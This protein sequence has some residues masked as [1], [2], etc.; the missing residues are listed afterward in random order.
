MNNITLLFLIVVAVV[1]A[2]QL[3][4][5]SR[6]RRSVEK[7]RTSVP[8]AF[9]TQISL[10]AHQKA[11]DYTVTKISVGNYGLLYGVVFLL[12]WTIGGGLELVDNSVSGFGLSTLWHGVI[13]MFVFMI[14][15]TIIDMPFSLYNTFV[16]EEKF[17]FNRMT[18]KTM[19]GD[20]VKSFLLMIIIG[21]PLLAVILWLM[22]ESGPNWWIYVWAVWMGFSLL[23]L[24]AYPA[25]IA[26]IFNKF[27]P[28]D[29]TQLVERIESLLTRCGFKSHGVFVMD[30]S[31][32]SAHGNAY[33]SGFGSNKRI[34]FFDTLLE[35]LDH[36][37]IEAVLAHELG[38]FRLKHV[39]KRIV[40]SAVITL[41]A[42][43]ILGLLAQ[44][45]WFFN[46]LGV[47]TP[48]SHMALLLFMMV[49]PLLTFFIQPILA[50]GSRK[51]EFEAD[52]FA[53]ENV[54]SKYLITALVKMYEEN[55]STL[56]PDEVYSAFHDSHPPAP[57]RIKHLEQL[58]SS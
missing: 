51:H 27:Q 58:A 10:E 31:K 26:P 46:S 47:S 8:E 44:E 14:A 43:A 48:S 45:Q 33:F 7:H 29:N 42:L 21:V 23:M 9:K 18:V 12:L 39:P 17:G 55:A 38:H 25:V 1:T 56:T 54:N 28:L 16:V 32:R 41:I 37:E 22:N 4:L 35:G 11:A 53:A 2:T 3:Y 6:Q 15:S 52:A 57:I 19:L 20:L 40:L 50:M 49:F 13:V 5:N 24:W 36:D 34:V 30:G